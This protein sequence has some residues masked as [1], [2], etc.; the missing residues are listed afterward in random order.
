MPADDDDICVPLPCLDSDEDEPQTHPL[1]PPTSRTVL[2]EALLRSL[3]EGSVPA[4]G[5]SCAAAQLQDLDFWRSLADEEDLH[6]LSS[7]WPDRDHPATTS[8]PAG[9]TAEH[10]ASLRHSLDVRG[11]LPPMSPVYTDAAALAA[12]CR[13]CR[14]LRS[15]AFA[16]VWIFVFDEAWHVLSASW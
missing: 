11:Y 15:L 16:P 8:I 3:A 5:L 14:R 4:A 2:M 12:L 1:D 9:N 7:L 13:M 10:V 6:V